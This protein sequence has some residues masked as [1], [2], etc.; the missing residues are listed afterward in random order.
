MG[1]QGQA[2]E[3]MALPLLASPCPV[4]LPHL[5]LWSS[6]P[7]SKPC[8][9]TQGG[10]CPGRTLALAVAAAKLFLLPGPPSPSSGKTLVTA[11]PIPADG[12]PSR[13]MLWT[14]GVG[15]NDQHMAGTCPGPEGW[16]PDTVRLGPDQL[17]LRVWGLQ[18]SAGVS[19]VCVPGWSG[20]CRPTETPGGSNDVTTTQTW[21]KLC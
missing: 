5:H 13:K 8:P 9:L 20:P 12:K 14:A 11:G 17:R 6:G 2:P 10:L 1:H 16:G 7:A 18:E 19:G 21:T 3:E 15:G 4:P